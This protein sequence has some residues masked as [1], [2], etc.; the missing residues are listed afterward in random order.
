MEAEDAYAKLREATRAHALEASRIAVHLS[1]D[2]PLPTFDRAAMAFTACA[3]AL[4]ALAL[5][6][7]E[8]QA[9]DHGTG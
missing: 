5:I 2:K 8:R 9:A 4:A 1:S 3:H 7:A 6:Q